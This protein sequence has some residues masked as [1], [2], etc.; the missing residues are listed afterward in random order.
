MQE[1]DSDDPY[2]VDM[3]EYGYFPAETSTGHHTYYEKLSES[4]TMD[5]MSANPSQM[6]PGY[7]GGFPARSG[8]V[9]TVKISVH[10]GLLGVNEEVFRQPVDDHTEISGHVRTV[11]IS[12]HEGLLG[13]NEEMFRQPVDDH[14]EMSKT[15]S[16]GER[17]L[18]DDSTVISSPTTSHPAMEESG[19]ETHPTQPI[20]KSPDASSLAASVVKPVVSHE[21]TVKRVETPNVSSPY[22]INLFHTRAGILPSA[23]LFRRITRHQDHLLPKFASQ[24]HHEQERKDYDG[25]N[26]DEFYDEFFEPNTIETFSTR[27][28][29]LSSHGA[30]PDDMESCT[31]WDETA[32]WDE[33]KLLDD[34][35]QECQSRQSMVDLSNSVPIGV[36]EGSEPFSDLCFDGPIY[37][38]NVNSRE[39][40]NSNAHNNHVNQN[41]HL[42][43]IYNVEERI[44]SDFGGEGWWYGKDKRKSRRV[45]LGLGPGTIIMIIVLGTALGMVLYGLSTQGSGFPL[46]ES[47][48][49][50]S[51]P[52]EYPTGS[53]LSFD[54]DVFLPEP[55]S[56]TSSPTSD[57]ASKASS[58][59][60]IAPSASTSTLRNPVPASSQITKQPTGAPVPETAAP[61]QPLKPAQA[62]AP[63][64]KPRPKPAPDSAPTHAP[65]TASPTVG[66]QLMTLENIVI[67][68]K[69]PSTYADLNGIGKRISPSLTVNGTE[70]TPSSCYRTSDCSMYVTVHRYDSIYLN[71]SDE[72]FY[73]IGSMAGVKR[74]HG[75]PAGALEF[76][77]RLEDGED[78]VWKLDAANWFRV[79][80]AYETP[81][82]V[83]VSGNGPMM[84]WMFD[85]VRAT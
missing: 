76:R 7:N 78:Y 61:T 71:D 47:T 75:L 2:G 40:V 63:I 74:N 53:P 18:I 49:S 64:V 26:D 16:Q 3:W 83:D 17:T 41:L 19:R 30:Y 56:P 85:V 72:W 5:S 55:L 29:S 84:S 66:Q 1:T 67:R 77:V 50:S 52:T 62:L 28:M 13:V 48:S 57:T 32:P 60:T 23:A 12:V 70:F 34:C 38:T 24:H 31:N 51:S 79:Q 8:H 10:E 27:T 65:S 42:P 45:C 81:Y 68:V 4:C 69:E 58:A 43:E 35:F 59:P 33:E 80:K 54:T 39:P 44:V 15:E 11:K 36:F 22:S 25:K 20:A 46:A 6:N 73:N 37:Q 9:R 82:R 14:T 21:G